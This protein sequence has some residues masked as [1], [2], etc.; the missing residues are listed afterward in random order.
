MNFN[1]F[2][3]V[4][5][6]PAVGLFVFAGQ[7]SG[8]AIEFST[9]AIDMGVNSA[10]YRASYQA[11]T[12]AETT[13]ALASFTNVVSGN[14]SFSY[15]SIEFTVGGAYAASNFG[16]QIASDAGYGGA[17]YLDGV[18]VDIDTTD[19]WW[20]MDWNAISEMLQANNLTSF[21]GNHTL[22]A[23]WAEG[24]CAGAQSA[25][26]T[27]D[28]GLTYR[29][30]SVANLAALNVPEPGTLAIVGLGLVALGSM[31]RRQA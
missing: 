21:T 28:N 16:F 11:Q 9:R 22:E 23:Y 18:Q 15:L 13:Q 14:N 8:A 6:A 19:M 3:K 4:L 30:M 25:R 26:F 20:G 31:R 1:P 29:E 27:T 24:C 2:I 7:A 10:D 17:L 12:S 5:A